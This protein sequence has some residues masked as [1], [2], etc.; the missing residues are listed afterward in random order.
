[1]VFRKLNESGSLD[2]LIKAVSARVQELQDEDVIDES[3]L[4]EITDEEIGSM[5]SL[6]RAVTK[7]INELENDEFNES[8]DPEYDS[9]YDRYEDREEEPTF[10]YYEEYW[11]EFDGN[12][13]YEENV[14]LTI[15][16]DDFFTNFEQDVKE[17][18][19]ESPEYIEH[20]RVCKRRIQELLN[21]GFKGTLA[22]DISCTLFYSDYE[23]SPQTLEEPESY[24]YELGMRNFEVNEEIISE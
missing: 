3:I 15:D 20:L 13:S 12:G 5:D 17:L 16:K 4:T 14:N 7:R 22:Y 21:T 9:Y 6:I 1:M 18:V 23:Y 2:N 8:Y 24:Y 19:Q 10:G 11:A